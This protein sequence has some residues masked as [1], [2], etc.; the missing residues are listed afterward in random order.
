MPS[1]MRSNLALATLLTGFLW[2]Q[3]ISEELPCDVK[4]SYTCFWD[5][6][7]KFRKAVED[8]GDVLSAACSIT[9]ELPT[10][11]KCESL[12]VGCMDD[13]KKQFLTMESGYASLHN[14]TADNRTC[15]P[16]R[17]QRDCDD[18]A[19]MKNCSETGIEAAFST[20]EEQVYSKRRLSRLLFVL[21]LG[22]P[23][24]QCRH[25]EGHEHGRDADHQVH[26][27]MDTLRPCSRPP[28]LTCTWCRL[29]TLELSLS[30]LKTRQRQWVNAL[31]CGIG[32]SVL[33]SQTLRSGHATLGAVA[34][35]L[36]D[37]PV[38]FDGRCQRCDIGCSSQVTSR[39]QSFI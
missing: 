20:F 18:S 28:R 5:I 39:N 34:Q 31:I 11:N 35:R 12:Y 17:Y 8:T 16:G 29:G 32:K 13:E 26:L 10:K 14:I 2:T 30:R 25:E 27:Q 23:G 7:T 9:K 36:G 24:V 38:P 21:R 4:A 33:H 1:T 3:G 19:G 37:A 6:S 22:L 15:T